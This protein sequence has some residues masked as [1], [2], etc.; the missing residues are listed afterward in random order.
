MR[1]I[2]N[3][4]GPCIPEEHYM[5]PTET[6][7]VDL[8]RLVAQRQYF[9]LHA[10]RQTGKTTLI[11]N[12]VSHLNQ[13]GGVIA[14]Y[15]SLETAQGVAEPAAGIPILIAELRQAILESPAAPTLDFGEK[16]DAIPEVALK[17]ALKHYCS[18]L[19]LPLVIMFDEVDCLSE[20][21]LLSF[22]RQMRQGYITRGQAPF[23]RSMGLV[24]MRNI[25]DYSMH[26]RPG[27]ET[28]GSASPFNIVSKALTLNNFA[29]EEVE[30]LLKQHTEDGGRPFP[31]NVVQAI[32]AQ[33]LGQPWLCNALAAELTQGDLASEFTAAQVE[34]AVE[35]IV[36]RRD[37]HIDSL[38][39][40]LKE[41]RVRG[42]MEPV[43][44]GRQVNLAFSSDD[45]AYVFDLGLLTKN[46]GDVIPANPIYKEVIMRALTYESQYQLPTSLSGRF[47]DQGRLD[48]SGLLQAFQQFWRENSDI[49]VDRFEYKGAAPHLILQ[50]YLQRVIN[51]GGSIS[52]E[53]SAGRGRLDLCV[54]LNGYRYPLELKIVRGPKTRDQG[55]NQLA[56][57][58]ATLGETQGWLILFNNDSNLDWNRKITWETQTHEGFEIH[59]VG[60]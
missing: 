35:T 5:V 4:A 33:T 49:W 10:P 29:V 48:M 24:G 53:Y 32:Y 22:L 20:R 31:A 12:F 17:N 41:P 16:L 45:A 50:A 57:Y 19:D 15:C 51:G 58:M 23:V 2:F 7:C 26:L 52:R 60:C 37:T 6:R 46:E 13:Q 25:R 40:R 39:E 43:I 21:V 56:G 38:L 27:R 47:V 9:V 28:M 1:K 3:I 42:I 59:V 18:Q 8:D 11:Q 34:R 36:L 54:S 30:A 44:L 14:L 55:L